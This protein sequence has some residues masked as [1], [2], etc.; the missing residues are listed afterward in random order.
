M[1]HQELTK[2]Q[3]EKMQSV[4]Y[5]M[6]K[7]VARDSFSEFLEY[8]DCTNDDWKIIKKHIQDRLSVELY[9]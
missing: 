1:R 5:Y 3:H 7:T 9:I 2:L 4:L 8:C 6:G